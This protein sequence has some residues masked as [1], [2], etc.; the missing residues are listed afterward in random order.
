MLSNPSECLCIPQ[1][2]TFTAAV[3]CVS[4]AQGFS[5]TLSCNDQQCTVTVYSC[6]LC[7]PLLLLL[8][9]CTPA[10]LMYNSVRQLTSSNKVLILQVRL[11]VHGCMGQHCALHE[12]GKRQL[13]ISVAVTAAVG[14]DSALATPSG[15]KCS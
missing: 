10:G 9:Q 3:Y 11:G 14:P 15:V 13:D 5:N 2:Q 4:A 1:Q 7:S 12:P 8:L 6:V